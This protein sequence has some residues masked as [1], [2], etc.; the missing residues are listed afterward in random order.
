MYPR[1][2]RPVCLNS[3]SETSDI[4]FVVG[5]SGGHPCLQ[6]EMD[7]A[8]PSSRGGNGP[9]TLNI[10]TSDWTG[11]ACTAGMQCSSTSTPA[12]GRRTGHGLKGQKSGDALPPPPSRSEHWGERGLRTRTWVHRSQAGM[13]N[14]HI[15]AARVHCT[16]NSR[17]QQTWVYS[18]IGL[19]TSSSLPQLAAEAEQ[20]RAQ[21]HISHGQP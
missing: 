4:E 1:T 19:G 13:E 11:H 5:S 17:L 9:Q 21:Q 20:L 2:V 3:T 8:R 15:R 16:Y 10:D 12:C 18:T 14:V 7:R 6:R